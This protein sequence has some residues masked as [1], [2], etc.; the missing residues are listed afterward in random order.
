MNSF[1]RAITLVVILMIVGVVAVRVAAPDQFNAIFSGNNTPPTTAPAPA[2][3]V[4]PAS[5]PTTPDGQPT[6]NNPA[7]EPQQQPPPPPPPTN[8]H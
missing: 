6:P 7:M 2:Q 5:S 4:P 3:P 1:G 8:P